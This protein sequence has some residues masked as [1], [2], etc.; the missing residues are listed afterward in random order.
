MRTY[1][2]TTYTQ[3]RAKVKTS[4]SG[5]YSPPIK[6]RCAGVAATINELD[7]I[8]P[9]EILASAVFEQSICSMFKVGDSVHQNLS[10]IINGGLWVMVV[11][12]IEQRD[13]TVHL[14]LC[15]YESVFTYT[16]ASR[17]KSSY[18]FLLYREDVVVSG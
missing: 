11:G 15:L 2:T 18:N 5:Y 17:G 4:C 6:V 7:K 8:C 9:Y 10:C 16:K 13:K 3:I 1:Q 14:V 12:N